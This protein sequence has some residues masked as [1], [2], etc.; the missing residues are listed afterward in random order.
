METFEKL[1]TSH[2]LNDPESRVKLGLGFDFYHLP[3]EQV[4]GVFEKARSLGTKIIT[5]HFIQNFVRD[6][7]SLPVLLKSYGLLQ[8]GMVLSHAGG[9]TADDVKLMYN[10][11]CFVSATPSTEL[12]MAVGPPVCFRA[13]LPGID[14]ICSL[15]VDCHSATSG[16]MVN[17]MRVALQTARG[18]ENETHIRNRQWPRDVSYKTADVFNMATIQ[19]A[20]A[21][22]MEEDIGSIKVGKKAD[23]VVFDTLSP[24]MS[25][26]AQRDP[27]MAIVL[28]SNIRDVHTV[29]VDGEVKKQNGKLC[30]VRRFEWHS[31]KG[32]A[33]TDHVIHWREVAD[34]IFT[35][36]KRLVSRMPESLLLE[37]EDHIRERFGHK[38]CSNKL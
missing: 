32:Y 23:L 11:N 31:G 24:A 7:E 6:S 16:S 33:D 21:L 17:E 36:H 12:A 38:P 28:H 26:V 1:A 15:G 30:P 29:L 8:K 25:C 22:C 35:I 37:I 2:P 19:G 14:P 5:S 34:R 10:A 18:I 9:A 13:D 3:K 4:L 27:V 20:R